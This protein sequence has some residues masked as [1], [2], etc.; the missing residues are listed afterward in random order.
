[1]ATSPQIA[2]VVSTFQRPDHLERC[3]VSIGAQRGVEGRFEVAVTDDG[4]EDNTVDLVKSFA[5]QA[6]F[7][8]AI[9]THDHRGFHLARCRNEGVRATRAPYLLFTDGDCIFPPDHLAVHLDAQRP[10]TAVAGDSLRLDK[11]ATLRIDRQSILDW[12]V[13]AWVSPAERQRLRQKARWA[14]VYQALRV[15]MRPRLTGNNIALWRADF[16]RVNGFDERFVGWGLEDRDIQSRLERAGL[17][18]RSI[19]ARSTPI[20]LWHPHDPTFARDNVNTPNREIYRSADRPVFC[21][22]GLVGEAPSDRPTLVWSGDSERAPVE[23]S[24]G[25]GEQASSG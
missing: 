25:F 19:I 16:E 1:M 13:E 11:S 20:H 4:S 8:V 9:T 3:L 10:G 12:E 6:R 21:R 15:P 17:K 22:Q 5:R 23:P 7:R 14:K 18:V 2:V 24:T